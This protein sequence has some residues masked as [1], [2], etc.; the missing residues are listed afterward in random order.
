MCSRL[1][2]LKDAWR[3]DL[4]HSGRFVRFRSA[5]AGSIFPLI[6]NLNYFSPSLSP[7]GS[8]PMSLPIDEKRK[9]L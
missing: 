3:I 1:V 8:A 2:L 5:P 7:L 6:D 9:K 4:H